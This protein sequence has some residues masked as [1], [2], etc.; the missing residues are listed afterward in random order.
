MVIKDHINLSGEN[1]AIGSEAEK[2][3]ERFFDM[4]YAYD[5]EIIEKSKDVYKKT[6]L[7]IKKVYTHF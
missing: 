3:G 7:I 5:R 4:T 6:G 1:P 2:F